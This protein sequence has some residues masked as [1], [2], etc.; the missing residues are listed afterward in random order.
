MGPG[1]LG[2]ESTLTTTTPKPSGA[3]TSSTAIPL[4]I[5]YLSGGIAGRTYKVSI[6]TSTQNGNLFEDDFYVKVRDR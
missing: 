3:I 6:R 4:V 2:E 1:D 5:P